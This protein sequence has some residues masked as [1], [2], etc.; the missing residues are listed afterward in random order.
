MGREQRVPDEYENYT[1]PLGY[2]GAGV[3]ASR[4]RVQ[5]LD[6][7]SNH[8]YPQQGGHI[9]SYGQQGEL[10]KEIVSLSLRRLGELDW[11]HRKSYGG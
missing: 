10:P 5:V 4:R 1:S 11:H 9:P 2:P 8:G 6:D 3:E 7:A